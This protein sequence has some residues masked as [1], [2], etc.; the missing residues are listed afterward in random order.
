M[1]L[2]RHRRHSSGGPPEIPVGAVGAIDVVGAVVLGS[3][4]EIPVGAAGAIDAVGA[5]VLGSPLEIL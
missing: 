3:P 5:V 4:P 2:R 1:R